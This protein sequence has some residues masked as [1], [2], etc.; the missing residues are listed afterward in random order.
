MK[1]KLPKGVCFDL[2]GVLIDATEWHWEA[3]NKALNLFG[4]T[5]GRDDHIKVYN[6]LPT[7]EKLRIMTEKQNLP[8]GL[9]SVIREQKKIYTNELIQRY[10]KPAYDKILML[11]YLKK[12][13]VKLACC[14]NAI[15]ESVEDMLK[16]AKLYDYFDVVMGN[17]KGFKPKPEPDIYLQAFCELF[18]VFEKGTDQGKLSVDVEE[19]AI[20]E[21]A[22]HGIIAAKKTGAQVIVVSGYSDVNLNLFL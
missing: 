9:H 15:T 14:S 20:V 8:E 18:A 11:N 22:P 13:G 2:D 6:G 7:K 17:D 19:I 4:Y 10:C 16:R 1:T 21:D 12:N 5:I 3:L